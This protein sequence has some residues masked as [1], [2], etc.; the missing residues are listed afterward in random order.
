MF[1]VFLVTIM[2][3][4][5][6]VGAE[7]EPVLVD[8]PTSRWQAVEPEQLQD[9]HDT[10]PRRSGGYTGTYTLQGHLLPH[11]GGSLLVSRQ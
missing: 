8:P 6:V 7:T 5:G 4:F 1:Q 3:V 2:N 9:R 11:L 10:S